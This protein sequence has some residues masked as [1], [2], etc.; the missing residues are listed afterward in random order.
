MFNAVEESTE[1]GPLHH[2]LVSP[3]SAMAN[4]YMIHRQSGDDLIGVFCPNLKHFGK[5]NRRGL[6][7]YWYLDDD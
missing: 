7:D 6:P 2:A 3:D 5:L 4:Q 1:F